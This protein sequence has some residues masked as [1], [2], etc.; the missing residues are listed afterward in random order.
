MPV[1]KPLF[2][3]ILC[4]FFALVLELIFSMVSPGDYQIL[5]FSK[6]NLLLVFSALAEE[7]TKLAVIYKSFPATEKRKDIIAGSLLLGAG[8]AATEI[9]LNIYNQ[10]N[11]FPSSTYFL[12]GIFLVH[13]FTAGF[14]GYL[15]AKKQNIYFIAVR[16][17]IF[18]TSVHLLYNI[19]LLYFF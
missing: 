9:F 19:M 15:L 18:N 3:G 7:A 2:L 8:F 4:A 13:V 11:V 12:L 6:I 1:I 5:F 10:Q 14:A 17:I 16:T